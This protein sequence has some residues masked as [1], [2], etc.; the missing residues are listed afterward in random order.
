MI[1]ESDQ[2]MQD[3]FR[4]LFKKQGYRVLVTSDPERL[5]Q[6][7]YDDVKAVDVLLISSGQLGRE[8]LDAFNKL[9]G[10]MRT[11]LIPTVLAAG[12]RPRSARRGSPNQPQPHRGEDASQ[13]PRTPRC[14]LKG[15]C[16]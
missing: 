11:K 12:R 14:D 2:K 3:L 8:A 7:I 6:R 16:G 10:D 15:P 4:E 9:G 5:F 1:V 13:G